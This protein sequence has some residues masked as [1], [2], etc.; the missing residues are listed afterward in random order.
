MLPARR[1][2]SGRGFA[3]DS[4]LTADR[5]L[6]NAATIGHYALVPSKRFRTR[7]ETLLVS[8]MAGATLLAGLTVYA[9]RSANA[10]LG[11]G[12][13]SFWAVFILGLVVVVVPVSFSA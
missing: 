2:R 12:P 9:L 7:R 6:D 3:A 1:P 5:S 10:E 11:D 13:I 8:L 4:A